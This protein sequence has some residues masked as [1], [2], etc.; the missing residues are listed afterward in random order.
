MIFNDDFWNKGIGYSALKLW[1]KEV[2]NQR[3][4]I[5]RI[6]LTTWSGNYGMVKLAE[7]IGMKEEARYRNAR[8]V[9][10]HYYDSVSYGMLKE[11]WK[12]NN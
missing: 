4:E 2:F 11:E 8:I 10:N 3:E 7:K 1:I 12:K 5:V 6:G 9:N